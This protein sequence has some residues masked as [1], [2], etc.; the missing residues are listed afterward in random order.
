MSEGGVP[1]VTAHH[2]IILS[3]AQPMFFLFLFLGL[4]LPK[5]ERRMYEEGKTRNA[6]KPN[7]CGKN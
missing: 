6:E 4:I 3:R 7:Y 2:A 1:V 5:K